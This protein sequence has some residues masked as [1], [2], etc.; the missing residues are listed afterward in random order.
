MR[1]TRAILSAA[2]FL[3]ACGEDGTKNDG[4]LPLADAAAN[5][6]AADG[7]TP[8]ARTADAAA[9]DARAPDALTPDAAPPP[10]L[11][12]PRARIYAGDPITDDGQLTE[13]TLPE[14]NNPEGRLTN[15]WANVHNCINE[16]GGLTATPDLGGLRI[17]VSLCHEVQTA[18]PDADGHYLSIA[19]PADDADPNDR[20]AEVMMYFHVNR[21]HDFFKGTFGFT[22]RDDSLY[23]LVNVQFKTE[24]RLP[25]PGLDIGP[26]GWI[27]FPN[28]AYFP[29]ESWNELAQS[30]GLPP[31]E[32]DSIIFGQAS[33]DFAYDARVIYH[34]YTHAVI[35]TSRL[36]TRVLDAYGLN[37]DPRAMNEGLA[38]YFAASIAGD[39]VIGRYGLGELDATAVRDLSVP[40]RC[41][42]DLADE[43]HADGRIIGSATWAI[44]D[45]IGAEAADRIIFRALEQFGPSTTMP[46][47]GE[48]ILAEAAGE[49]AEIEATVRGILRDF[50]V[51]E[52]ERAQRLTNWRATLLPRVVEGTASAGVAGLRAFVPGFAQHYVDVPAGTAAV[53]LSWTVVGGGGLGGLGAVFG[54]GGP[55]QLG[56]AVRRGAPVGIAVEDGAAVL[57]RDA[58]IDPPATRDDQVYRQSVVLGPECLGDA[59][60]LYLMFLNRQENPANILAMKAEP[61]DALPAEDLETCGAVVP[62]AGVG[63]DAAPAADAGVASDAGA[64]AD[65]APA[66]AARPAPDA[67]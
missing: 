62:D 54:G 25:I 47:A 60:R 43:V 65:A 45:A 17:T 8:D 42:A 63:S 1:K 46:L 9:A 12:E 57:T 59:A 21:V 28:A 20:F 18:R 4:D 48:L 29:E 15:A 24:P 67:Q 58:E 34:E 16:P 41:P 51:I 27:A 61:L 22:G 6:A 31:R 7:A 39:A 14:T 19:P 3:A 5:D 55:A 53:R 49:G 13:V 11:T 64:D 33:V 50:G 30:F 10:H 52:C 35:G 40:R 32:G 38:D 2:L 26:D 66:D 56:V 44:R 23:S 36:Q 37:D